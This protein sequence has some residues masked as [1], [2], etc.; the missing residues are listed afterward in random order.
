MWRLYVMIYPY[1]WTLC[2]MLSI[3]IYNDDLLVSD[4]P[5]CVVGG[6]STRGRTIQCYLQPARNLRHRSAV[7]PATR[8]HVLSVDVPRSGPPLPWHHGVT[9]LSQCGW[10]GRTSY[11]SRGET[12]F[13]HGEQCKSDIVTSLGLWRHHG[14][15][16]TELWHHGSCELQVHW[17]LNERLIYHRRVSKDILGNFLS[18][19]H[20]NRLK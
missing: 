10:F 12:V 7:S 8:Q 5:S 11:H 15:A 16:M 2:F 17:W 13:D 3:N 14:G 18:M 19:F 9:W 6:W 20:R 4:V 1:S